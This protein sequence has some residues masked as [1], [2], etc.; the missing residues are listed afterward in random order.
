MTEKVGGSH[1][2]VIAFGISFRDSIHWECL[3]EASEG[4]CIRLL[5]TPVVCS[6]SL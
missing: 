5:F 6:R 3:P 2:S 4:P 1:P